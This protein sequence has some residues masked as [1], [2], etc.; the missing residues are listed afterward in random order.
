MKNKR[1]KRRGDVESTYSHDT[2]HKLDTLIIVTFVK[3][4]H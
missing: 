2:Q 3:P 1:H 4:R